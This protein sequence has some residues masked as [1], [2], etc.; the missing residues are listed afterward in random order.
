MID[1]ERKSQ[2]QILQKLQI[3]NVCPWIVHGLQC[4]QINWSAYKEQK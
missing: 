1:Y 4:L 3:Q 2:K